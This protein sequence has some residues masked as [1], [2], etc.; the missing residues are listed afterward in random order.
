MEQHVINGFDKATGK[1]RTVRIRAESLEAAE[2]IARQNGV[3]SEAP[4]IEPPPPPDGYKALGLE[5]RGVGWM[6]IVIGLILSPIIIGI[7]LIVWG[8]V[9]VHM[10][11]A[12]EKSRG[13]L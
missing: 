2:R 11:K 3:Y 4:M 9:S 7:P 12:H 13:R 5:S 10:L 8:G 6:L 1:P